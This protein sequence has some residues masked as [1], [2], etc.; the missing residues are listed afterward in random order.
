MRSSETKI[1]ILF[2]DDDILV[3]NKPSGIPCHATVDKKRIHLLSLLGSHNKQ[4]ILLHRLDVGTSGVVILSKNSA[5]N[6]KLQTQLK[7]R[8]IE[9]YYWAV[10]ENLSLNSMN[11]NSISE[12]LKL[13]RKE[14]LESKTQVRLQN[15][16]ASTTKNKKEMMLP[17]RT[18]GDPAISLFR[19]LKNSMDWI[20]FEVQIITGRK[21]QIRSH[22][23]SLCWPIIQD[24]L[25]N[26][27]LKI[28]APRLG[29][30][31]WKVK[32]QHPRTGEFL[33][34]ESPRPIE[35]SKYF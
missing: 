31:S 3:V 14:I 24:T 11:K 19:C 26:E 2:E 4:L 21:H 6:H 27:S 28:S 20:S 12:E 8:Q 7:N 32:F 34:I 23:K 5:A 35:F 33:K 17:V 29:L 25:Y 1:D 10:S 13:L 18:G 16:L 30:H 9:K 22:L 15:Y